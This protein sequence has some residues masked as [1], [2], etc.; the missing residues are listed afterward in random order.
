MHSVLQGPDRRRLGDRLGRLK[1]QDPPRWGR[2]SCPQMLAHLNDS[3]RMALGELPVRSKRAVFRYPPLKQ[4]I[5][6]LMPFP[7]GVPTAPELLAR[8]DQ[9]TWEKE[10]S[11]LPQ[12]MTRLAERS[13]DG[14]WPEHPAFGRLTRRAWGVLTYRHIDHHFRQFGV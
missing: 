3:V 1:P 7:K 2:M 5:V 14:L 6:Y 10:H 13:P 11:M 8:I 4:L 12:L 9:A